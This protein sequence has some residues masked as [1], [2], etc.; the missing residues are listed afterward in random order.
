MADYLLNYTNKFLLPV[1]LNTNVIELRKTSEFYELITSGGKLLAD[2]IIVTTGTNPNAYIPEFAQ[3][4]DKKTVQIHS[5][6]Y[7]NPHL[8]PASNT[9]VVGAGTSG[10][11]IA[12]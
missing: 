5:S 2:Y 7:K 12:I 11:E 9:L 4:I 3:S 6:E 1:Q 8:F 10:V